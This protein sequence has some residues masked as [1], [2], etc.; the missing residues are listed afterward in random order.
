MKI[1]E[2]NIIYFDSE[3][4][5]IANYIDK[6]WLN[7]KGA[8]KGVENFWGKYII[9]FDSERCKITNYIDKIWVNS[10]W[11]VEG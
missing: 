11:V 10:K 9:Y 1:F 2:E 4:C 3:H 5:K 7:S 8:V 6:I